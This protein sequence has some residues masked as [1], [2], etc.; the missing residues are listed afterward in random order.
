M[1]AKLATATLSDVGGAKG[2]TAGEIGSIVVK[3][4]GRQTVLALGPAQLEKVL[5]DHIG[6]DEAKAV[7]DLFKRFGR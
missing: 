1:E 4:L 3:E 5:K 7:K 2:A 6:D